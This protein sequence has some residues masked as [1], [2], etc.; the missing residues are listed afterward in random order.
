[1]EANS[2]LNYVDEHSGGNRKSSQIKRSR[3][4]N[5]LPQDYDG[6]LL[7]VPGLLSACFFCSGLQH[8]KRCKSTAA[9]AKKASN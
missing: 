3:S 5:C 2:N 8:I 7:A 4:N 6:D 1:M 9:L